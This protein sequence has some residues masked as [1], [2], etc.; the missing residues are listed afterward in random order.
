MAT[1]RSEIIHFVHFDNETTIAAVEEISD[2]E[3]KEEIESMLEIDNSD[4]RDIKFRELERYNC[5][6]RKGRRKRHWSNDWQ[7]YCYASADTCDNNATS[8]IH[9]KPKKRLFAHRSGL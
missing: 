8:V 2:G 7:S 4:D 6:V 9:R 5:K 3:Q 1:E